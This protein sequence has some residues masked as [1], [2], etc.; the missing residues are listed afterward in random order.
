MGGAICQGYAGAALEAIPDGAKMWNIPLDIEKRVCAL[1]LE[2]AYAR[3]Y[4]YAD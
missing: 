3:K 1:R 2:D 4:D